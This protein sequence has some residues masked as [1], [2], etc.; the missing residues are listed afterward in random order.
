M[1]SL[2]LKNPHRNALREPWRPEMWDRPIADPNKPEL[3]SSLTLE[4]WQHQPQLAVP[5][6]PYSA[7][8]LYFK[9][10]GNGA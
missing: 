7:E 10:A 8:S 9:R 2:A 1:R 6:L 4:G 3:A 5:H